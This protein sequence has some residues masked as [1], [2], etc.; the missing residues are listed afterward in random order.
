MTTRLRSVTQR[1]GENLERVRIGRVRLATYAC[2]L[3]V[4]A[5]PA[6]ISLAAI[7]DSFSF[8]VI[9][10]PH[11][12]GGADTLSAQR[13]QACVDWVN[14]HRQSD[15]IDLVF[16]AGDI[17]FMG[18]GVGVQ[19]A[20]TILDNLAVPY[21]PIIGDDDILT[22]DDEVYF[23][24]TFEPIY[25]AL[26]VNPMFTNWSRAPSYVWDPQAG[27]WAYY[28]NF[29][30]DYRGVH[31]VC[32]DWCNRQ[33]IAWPGH[34]PIRKE[35]AEL[36][37]FAEGT[38]PWFTQD[39][40]N[41]AKEKLENIVMVAHHPMM[42]LG[43]DIGEVLASYGVFAP[44]EFDRLRTFLNDPSAN[45]PEHVWAAYGGHL[46]SPGFLPEDADP[47]RIQFQIQ[48]YCFDPNVYDPNGPIRFLPLPGYDLYAIDD[49][50]LEKSAGPDDPIR[51]EL[52][53]VTEGQ[54]RFNYVST[55]IVVPE[56][57]AIA[58]L[59]VAQCLR[60]RQQRR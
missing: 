5:G 27:M 15:K 59:L 40:L 11:I 1:V 7:G 45:L 54:D 3:A 56:P 43:G 9:A 52:I 17:G 28:Q 18:N 44:G 36:H 46:H 53:T 37:D 16:V 10:D 24:N 2:C 34:D 19:T 49:T 13:L 14:R 41:C 55:T 26:A 21:A 22:S 30:F 33:T 60:R 38:W 32:P 6:T 47:N 23:A 4:L 31:F 58:L 29:S 48:D 39:L 20:K 50:H 8:V 51:L 57:S 35:D 25:Q 12:S 42:T